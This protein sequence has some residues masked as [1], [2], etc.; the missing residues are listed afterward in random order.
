[1]NGYFFRKRGSVVLVILAMLL[2][3]AACV[4]DPGAVLVSMRQAGTTADG[5]DY[6]PEDIIA[7]TREGG[8][9][10]WFTFFDG[11]EHG[12]TAKHGINAFS[13]NE[14]MWF[15]VADPVTSEDLKYIPALYLTF[16]PNSIR[17]PGISG[18]VNGQ[19][20]VKYSETDPSDVGTFE[21]LFD[22][23]DVGLT[24]AMERIDGLGY[25]APETFVDPLYGQVCPA[26]IFFITTQ[27]VYRVRGAWGG[28]IVGSGFDVLMFCATS[29]G[30]DTD[31]AWYRVFNTRDYGWF[32]PGRASTSIDVIGFQLMT[33]AAP[34]AQGPQA[35]GKDPDLAAG[36][37][38]LF[39]PRTAFG[40]TGVTD[41]IFQPSNLYEIDTISNYPDID[42]YDTWADFNLGNDY[43]TGETF[44]PVN[45]L[46]N[47]ISI[48]DYPFEEVPPVP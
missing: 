43:F 14:L 23:S 3:A 38:F 10:A 36:I 34:E 18:R 44:P 16:A 39:T 25:W 17:V 2:F 15:G 33:P 19:D 30:P 40:I 22:G 13:F 41:R 46:V 27:G 31:G 4:T 1:M 35:L 9:P 5:L 24:T 29:V 20:I 48:W 32:T 12:L 6:G 45:G 21:V 8:D 28:Q 7:V 42:F 37:D 11:S 47:S 26:G